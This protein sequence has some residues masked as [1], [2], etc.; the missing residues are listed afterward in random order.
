MSTTLV[1]RPA[2]TLHHC[3]DL[4]NKYI[5]RYAIFTILFLPFPRQAFDERLP[6]FMDLSNIFGGGGPRTRADNR[7][8]LSPV[9]AMLWALA[10]VQYLYFLPSTLS[11][12]AIFRYNSL[13]LPPCLPQTKPQKMCHCHPVK[14]LSVPTSK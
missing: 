14:H 10:R 4:S 9:R 13:P 1:G 8:R 7:K 11:S 12:L 6:E 5:S 2:L 3:Q